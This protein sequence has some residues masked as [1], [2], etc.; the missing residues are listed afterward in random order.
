MWDATR[1]ECGGVLVVSIEDA[2]Y[3]AQF[4]LSLV[5]AATSVRDLPVDVD[6]KRRAHG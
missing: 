2:S 5:V 6:K 1:A 4:T 3:A